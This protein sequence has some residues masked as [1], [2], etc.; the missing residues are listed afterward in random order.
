M[1]AHPLREGC[2]RRSDFDGEEAVFLSR[3]ARLA[4]GPSSGARVTAVVRLGFKPLL[5][6]LPRA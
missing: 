4:Q 1:G 2:A 5:P 6:E 3:L